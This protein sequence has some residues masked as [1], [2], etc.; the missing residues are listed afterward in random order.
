MVRELFC[1]HPFL[2]SS[3]GITSNYINKYNA[4]Y[5]YLH[6]KTKENSYFEW[7]WQPLFT[8]ISKNKQLDQF[9]WFLQAAKLLITIVDKT[10]T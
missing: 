9:F 6:T 4:S 8:L 3:T 2:F 1:I 7:K 5:K 10:G